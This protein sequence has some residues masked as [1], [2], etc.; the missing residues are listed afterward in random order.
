MDKLWTMKAC[1]FCYIPCGVSH[2]IRTAEIGATV[3]DI[4]S[5][6]REEYKKLGEG[7]SSST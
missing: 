7:F 4:F 2:G 5:P 1:D 6:P 3:L